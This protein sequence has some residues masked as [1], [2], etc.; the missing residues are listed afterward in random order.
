M[1]KTETLIRRETPKTREAAAGGSRKV[2]GYAI[3]FNTPSVVLWE[4]GKAEVREVIA[5]EAVTME[6]LDQQDI[7]MTMYHNRELILA[8]SQRGK[9]SLSY[10]VDTRGV[11]FEFDAPE[12]PNGDEA[13]SLVSRADVAGCSFMFSTFYDDPNYVERTQDEGKS[14]T[15][16]VRKMTGIYDFTLAADPA[17]PKT[18]VHAEPKAEEPDKGNEDTDGTEDSGNREMTAEA[19]RQIR[20]M[21]HA[22]SALTRI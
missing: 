15:Y 10:G 4:E 6:F 16:T 18:E 13:L 2:R 19:A 9:G 8:R 5:P 14:V 17:Y 11:W 12:S 3:L 22:A 21:R 1:P 7:K 20:Q